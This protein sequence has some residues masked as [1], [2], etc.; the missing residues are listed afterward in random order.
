MLSI[1]Q[2]AR[3][4]GLQRLQAAGAAPVAPV[5]SYMPPPGG[6]F[7]T[8][9]AESGST[10]PN[11][12]AGADYGQTR[13]VLLDAI[14]QYNQRLGG[15]QFGSLNPAAANAQLGQ[16][17]GQIGGIAGQFAGIGADNDPRYAAFQ[18]SQFGLFDQDAER[19][20]S[21]LATELARTGVRG[22]AATNEMNRVEQGLSA[23][24]Q[25]LSAQLGMNQ[26][27]RQDSA[28]LSAAGLYGQQAGIGQQ[29]F[30]NLGTAGAFN[31][32]ATQM[33]LEAQTGGLQNIANVLGIDVS[34]EAAMRSGQ[35]FSR[36][37]LA[38][39]LARYG[40]GPNVNGGGASPD[41]GYGG[42][43]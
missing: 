40:L 17:G 33:G 22:T 13:S 9:R 26:L 39:L 3:Q 15:T 34:R 41:T 6:G 42:G 37:D 43:P 30:G 10:I 35:G 19:Q 11:V 5:P 29:A 8:P 27:G 4:R 21:A 7:G 24:R 18:Q 12:P 20:R 23:R 38:T 28:L 32:A 16:I 36:G 31:N 14:N 1:D 2:A 25:D